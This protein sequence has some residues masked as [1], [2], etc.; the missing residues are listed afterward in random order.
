MAQLITSNFEG[1][2]V[3]ITTTA[4]GQQF[5]GEVL[6][7]VSSTIVT[8]KTSNGTTIYIANEHIVAFQ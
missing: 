5:T 2:T 4:Q 8:I 3:T 7:P 1:V 6:G